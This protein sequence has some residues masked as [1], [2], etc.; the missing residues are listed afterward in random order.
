MGTTVRTVRL[1]L[2]SRHVESAP[3]GSQ[4]LA[5]TDF[6]PAF[7]V[8]ESIEGS[9]LRTSC[10]ELA[11]KS[12]AV[13]A[14]CPGLIEDSC[15]KQPRGFPAKP[16][17]RLGIGCER[18]NPLGKRDALDLKRRYPQHLST[19]AALSVLSPPR[20]PHHHGGIVTGCRFVP[21]RQALGMFS[22]GGSRAHFSTRG[23]GQCSP[24]G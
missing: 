21:V 20:R 8:S 22:N 19:S 7:V 16:V 14:D 2:R 23:S 5:K 10:L 12:G 11:T 17:S 15:P 1:G 24:I 18:G 13:E 4:I 3:P 6:E 9:S